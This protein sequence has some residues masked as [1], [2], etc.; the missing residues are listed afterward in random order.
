MTRREEE[1]EEGQGRGRN[2]L[3]GRGGKRKV[4]KCSECACVRVCV[5][6]VCLDEGRGCWSSADGS[7]ADNLRQP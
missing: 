6:V 7:G 3:G 5:C 1:E 4:I 2:V